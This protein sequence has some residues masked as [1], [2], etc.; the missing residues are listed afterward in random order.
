MYLNRQKDEFVRRQLHS[1]TSEEESSEA[2][3]ADITANSESDSFIIKIADAL[4]NFS[5]DDLVSESDPDTSFEKARPT[6]PK[7]MLNDQIDSEELSQDSSVAAPKLVSKKKKRNRPKASIKRPRSAAQGTKSSSRSEELGEGSSGPISF[8]RATPRPLTK[9]LSG[10]VKTL[11]AKELDE[12]ALEEVNEAIV[13]EH[14]RLQFVIHQEARGHN[15]SVEEEQRRE[16]A[17]QRSKDLDDRRERLQEQRLIED[18]ERLEAARQLSTN[19]AKY[20][21]ERRMKKAIFEL[22]RRRKL[23]KQKR[24]I[25]EAKQSEKNKGLVIAN[26]KNY[27]A[28]QVALLKEQLHQEKQMRRVLQYEERQI[29]SA[30]RQE[31][32]AQRKRHLEEAKRLLQNESEKQDLKELEQLNDA[33][34]EQR[35]IEIYRAAK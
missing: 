11:W 21:V 14:Q 31:R 34:F 19:T 2:V 32:I 17:Y 6:V 8:G 22:N 12:Q 23:Q 16:Q 30:A 20:L 35:L 27:F 3:Q 25:H 24:L 13:K 26:V 28:D 1:I 33:E 7:L 15:L 9:A 18:L 5:P 4:A 29:L 10:K